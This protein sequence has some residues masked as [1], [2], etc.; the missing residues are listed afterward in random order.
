M[1]RPEMVTSSY[2]EW[3]PADAQPWMTGFYTLLLWDGGFIG[4]HDLKAVN[5][6][7]L[8]LWAWIPLP[9]PQMRVP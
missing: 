9:T 8:I 3:Y 5:G 2:I 6:P 7:D 4:T 1:D